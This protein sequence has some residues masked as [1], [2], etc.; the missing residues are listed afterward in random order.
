MRKVNYIRIIYHGIL[1]LIWMSLPYLAF[2][3][4]PGPKK[5]YANP[6][7]SPYYWLLTLSFIGLFY[8]YTYYVVP[9][10]YLTKKY[11]KFLGIVFILFV[12]FGLLKPF[13]FLMLDIMLRFRGQPKPPYNP[14]SI[15][16]FT[17]LLFVMIIT[18][19]LASQI[20][21][22]LRL[23][24]RRALQAET[25]K[26]TAELSFLKAQINPHFLF[27]T[28]NTIYSLILTQNPLAGGAVL[29]LSNI[30]RFVTDDA[31]S[32][33]VSLE[34]E[35]AFITDFV[36]LHR[37][38][39]GK[40]VEVD[41]S[42]TGN[43]ENK[44]I[45]PLILMTY[46]ENVFKYGISNHE[47]API[48]IRLEVSENMLVFFC[49]NRIFATPRVTERTGIG[50]LNTKKRLEYLYPDTHELTITNTR[51]LYTV[52]LTLPA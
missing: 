6:L 16:L 5:I 10:F 38:Q 22:Q 26:A 11:L 33:F 23:T 31:S 1:I 40:K 7:E 36:N 32:N 50:L 48:T 17:F 19:G 20:I 24:E 3:Q 35:V 12:V 4:K 29:E 34:K 51:D 27:N 28:L 44:Q 41:F 52:T 9:R 8:G 18:L 46:I 47:A 30:M 13:E 49:Q 42:V 43:L 25:E 15:D 14:I 45:A 2:Y 21:R 37:L 39:H